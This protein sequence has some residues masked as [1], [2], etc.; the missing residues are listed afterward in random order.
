MKNKVKNV[1][2]LITSK[3]ISKIGDILFD[4]A[5]NTFLASLNPTSLSMVAIYQSLESVIGVLF[6]LYGGV[7]ADNFKRK[8]I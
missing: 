6:N 7:I 4:F 3:G 5:N 2:Y 8:K 1:S